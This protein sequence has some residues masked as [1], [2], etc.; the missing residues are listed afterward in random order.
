VAAS[1]ISPPRGFLYRKDPESE[2]VGSY[3]CGYLTDEV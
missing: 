2:E 1:N 3:F